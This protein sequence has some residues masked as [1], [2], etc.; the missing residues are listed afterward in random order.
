MRA[1]GQW[2]RFIIGVSLPKDARGVIGWIQEGNQLI[3]CG[4][5]TS[6]PTAWRASSAS[7]AAGACDSG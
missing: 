2:L 3:C 4:R 1:G 6:L 7:S 5:T